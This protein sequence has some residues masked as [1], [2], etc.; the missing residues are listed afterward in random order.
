MVML[1]SASLIMQPTFRNS[2]LGS[3][4]LK[5]VPG[6]VS[7]EVKFPLQLEVDDI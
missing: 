6:R 3:K 4:I 1:R 2:S 7:T 5:I